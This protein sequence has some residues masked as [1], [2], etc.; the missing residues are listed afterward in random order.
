MRNRFV[1]G[2]LG[3]GGLGIVST[4]LSLLIAI[5]LARVLGA[6]GYGKYAFAIA[7]IT[8]VAIP[9]QIGLPALI[10]R[11]VAFSHAHEN[12][13]IMK[14]MR[15]RAFQLAGVSVVFSLLILGTLIAFNVFETAAHDRSALALALILLPLWTVL[16][17]KRSMLNG[18]RKVIHAAW[19]GSALQPA[20]FLMLLIALMFS[21]GS[22]SPSVAVGANIAATVVAV[23]AMSYL[24]HIFWP[25]QATVAKAEYNTRAWLSSLL[26]FTMIAG[27]NIINQK[28]DILMLGVLKG[29]EEVGIYNIAV[30]GSLLVSFALTAFNVVLVPNVARLYAQGEHKQLQRLLT[31]SAAITSVIAGATAVILVFSGQWLLEKVFGESFEEAYIPLCIMIFGQLVNALMGSV[32]YFLT[33]TGHEKETL[34]ALG[35]STAINVALNAV[36]IP[37]YGITGAAAATACSITIWNIILG[38]RVFHCL[39][40]VPGPIRTGK[41]EA[42]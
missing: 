36:L 17:L 10:V 15:R 4:G 22:L 42:A 32:G 11:E 23:I 28:T 35:I 1:Q 33:M 27:I 30:Q 25:Q 29:P 24:L 20:L 14:G 13:S 41:G 3:S 19:P 12:W 40:L 39:G 21:L 38:F 2:V 34:R 16:A 5:L 31:N 7:V 9:T 26:P 6:E 37:K 18:L 8:F